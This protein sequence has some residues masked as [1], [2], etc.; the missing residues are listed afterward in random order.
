MKKKLIGYYVLK[1]AIIRKEIKEIVNRRFLYSFQACEFYLKNGKS[2]YFNFY[3]EEKKIEFIS[4]FSDCEN[5]KIISDLKSEFK[6]KGFTKLWLNNRITT[7]AYLL[8]INKYSCRSYNDVNQYPVFPWLILHN[9]KER[10]LEYTTVAQ[11]ED[12]RTMLKEKY[13]FS[14]EHFPYHYT[15]HYSNASFL[16]YYLIQ[17]NQEK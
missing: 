7:F 16:I 11:D 10:D 15:T 12:T 1:I 13:P 8:F 5:I 9:D 2:Y 17:N 14:S 4:L 6:N 3:S